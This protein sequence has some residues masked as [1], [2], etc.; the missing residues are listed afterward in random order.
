MAY[1]DYLDQ[2]ATNPFVHRLGS[3]LSTEVAEKEYWLVVGLLAL[4]FSLRA[5]LLKRYQLQEI[6]DQIKEAK[7]VVFVHRGRPYSTLRGFKKWLET[8]EEKVGHIKD[9]VGKKLRG[10]V[11]TLLVCGFILPS[12][13]LGLFL[14][15]YS[16]FFPGQHAFL[17]PAGAGAPISNPSPWDVLWVVGV[18]LMQGLETGSQTAYAIGQTLNLSLT[19]AT[20][21]AD[22]PTVKWIILGYRYFIGAFAVALGGYTLNYLYVNLFFQNKQQEE[23][24]KQLTNLI[25]ETEKSST[26]GA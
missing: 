26:A 3:A 1:T 14:Y 6:R 22:D 11:S 8:L 25:E 23:F 12:L 9:D 10:G 24:K 13:L 20:F 19:G 4:G 17:A 7:D 5:A 18:Q 15:R 2:I 16:W 21:N